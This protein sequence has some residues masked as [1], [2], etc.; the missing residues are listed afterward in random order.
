M[1]IESE[2]T[3][4]FARKKGSAFKAACSTKELILAEFTR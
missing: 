3:V 2:P 4:I 1:T